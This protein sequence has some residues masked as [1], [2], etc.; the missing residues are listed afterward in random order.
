MEIPMYPRCRTCLNNTLIRLARGASG[1]DPKETICGALDATPP[2]D[3]QPCSVESNNQQSKH[4]PGNMY[5]A[6]EQ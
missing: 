1:L 6:A 4:S 3:G 5:Y 2:A